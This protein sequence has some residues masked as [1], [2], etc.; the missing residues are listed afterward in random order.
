MKV[1]RPPASDSLLALACGLAL[2]GDAVGGA[3]G[4]AFT[5][6]AIPLAAIAAAPLAWRRRAPVAVLLATGFG[7]LAF[8]V[9]VGSGDVAS[10]IAMIPLYTVAVLGDRRR[11]LIVGIV[12]A[13]VLA[14]AISALDDNGSPGS[15]AVRLLL[16]LSA[17]VVG[18]TVRSRRAL[19]L[20]NAARDEQLAREREME[21]ERLV[22]DERVRIARELHDSLGHS[23]VAINVRAGVSQ[24]IGDPGASSEALGE[25]KEVSASAL[26]DLRA[27]LDVLRDRGE[28][29]PTRPNQGLAGLPELAE[30]LR[31]GGVRTETE[32]EV[33]GAR[34]PGPLGQA[35]FR[36]VQESLTNVLRHA[37]ASRARVAVRVV[38]D[39]LDIEVTDDGG[40]TASADPGHGLRGM[41]ERAG[42]LGGSV[43]A[44][45]VPTGWR[46]HAR[47]PLDGSAA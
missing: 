14:A 8:I 13:L 19:R 1:R 41:A 21:S 3:D 33:S 18:D 47:L 22:A 6:L 5:A 11:S 7:L 29:A 10:L 32:V 4:H 40:E 34:I 38:A 35:T 36:I 24:H 46:V 28:D 26:R 25:I 45:P 30:S 37:G 23:L 17:L 43:E 12:S 42:A 44:G 15:G 27:T 16:I 31:A 2:I 39:S 20:A 9:A